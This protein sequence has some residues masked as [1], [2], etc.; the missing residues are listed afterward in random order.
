V[1][2]TSEIFVF[3]IPFPSLLSVDDTPCDVC[4]LA[5]PKFAKA[6]TSYSYESCPRCLE[7][8]DICFY[9]GVLPSEERVEALKELSE[10]LDRLTSA[11]EAMAGDCQ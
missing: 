9:N 10:E 8:D 4:I 3:L 7:T 1:R 5:G 11:F 6:C 2:F